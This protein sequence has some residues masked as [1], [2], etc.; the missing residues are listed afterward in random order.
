[1]LPSLFAEHALIIVLGLVWGSFLNVIAY[2]LIR[3]IPLAHPRRSFCPECKRQLRWQELIPLV[4]WVVLAGR[5]AGCK[6]PISW[7]YP[8]VELI[9]GVTALLFWNFLPIYQFPAYALLASALIITIR[10]DIELLTIHR[11]NTLALIPVALIGCALFA[12]P[13]SG[14]NS[15]FGAALGYGILALVRLVGNSIAGK[16]TLGS[17]DLELLATIGAFLGPVGCWATLLAGSTL[18]CITWMLLMATGKV[19]RTTPLPFGAF[20]ALTALAITSFVP[21]IS[22]ILLR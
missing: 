2:R 22:A 17:G 10:T 15:I 20:L 14:W 9:S 4:S 6:E 19:E 13:I 5:C 1:M 18:A 21:Q 3:E 16:N 12:N 8:F 7:L 11:S